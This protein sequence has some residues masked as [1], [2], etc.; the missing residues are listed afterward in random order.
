MNT[1]EDSKPT[2]LFERR[3]SVR[4]GS[5]VRYSRTD[6]EFKVLQVSGRYILISSVDAELDDE[7]DPPAHWDAIDNFEI[8][9]TVENKSGKGSYKTWVPIIV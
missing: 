4:S 8:E 1:F 7:E 2:E 3:T 6:I 9:S 5:T